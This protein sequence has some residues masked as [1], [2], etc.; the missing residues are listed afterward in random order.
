M[1]RRNAPS[2]APP[3]PAENLPAVAIANRQRKLPL[4]LRRIRGLVARALPLCLAEAGPLPQRLAELPEIAISIVGPDAMSRVHVDFLAIEGPTDVIT[5][6]YGEI[7][8][9]AAIAAE[10]CPR[11][12]NSLDD[13]VAL[14]IIHGL[15]H[16]NG[17]DDLEAGAARHM[18]ARQAKI[19]NA[20]RKT[21]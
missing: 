2:K 16:L 21:V 1:P 4:D 19:L 18:R 8:V 11:Y 9:C 17:F 7:L 12:G 5:F 20:A 13:E 10:N 14:Y 6:P 3:D 15:L